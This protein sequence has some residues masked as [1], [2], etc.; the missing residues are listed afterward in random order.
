MS[1]PFS[2]A[3]RRWPEGS[4]EGAGRHTA[5]RLSLR[6]FV[7]FA[8]HPPHL[9]VGHLL[10]AGEKGEQVARSQPMISPIQP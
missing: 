6:A 7:A 8:P 10:P 5:L 1:Y 2:P 9:P 3:G 4:D